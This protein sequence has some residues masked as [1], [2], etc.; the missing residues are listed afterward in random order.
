MPLH[1]L[2]AGVFAWRRRRGL[3]RALVLWSAVIFAL[4]VAL[5]LLVVAAM[6]GGASAA[7]T[8]PGAPMAAWTVTQRYGCT[9]FAFEPGRGPCAHFHFGI[10]LAAPA[11]S[12]VSA[13]AQGQVEVF[14]PAGLS[15]GYGLHVVV[16]HG[17][18]LETLYG[19]LQ[20][21]VVESGST[22]PV[23]AVLGHEGSTGLST[24][25]HLHFEVREA[26][27]AVDPSTVFPGIFGPDGHKQ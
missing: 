20:D 18:G 12:A 6:S 25:P 24:G 27:I 8:L 7:T 15:G 23:G 5:S 26:G 9:G 17:N 3:G 16:R 11:G 2:R 21:I 19:H 10:D 14:A 22:V 13:V 1:L 4:P